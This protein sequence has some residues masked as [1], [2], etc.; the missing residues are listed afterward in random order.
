MVL[1]QLWVCPD[2]RTPEWRD[3][4]I[5]GAEDLYTTVPTKYGD[6]PVPNAAREPGTVRGDFQGRL[7]E[8]L[9][10]QEGAEQ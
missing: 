4:P 7:K 8:V 1:Q 6:M 2:G 9:G 5:E 3:V 10:D